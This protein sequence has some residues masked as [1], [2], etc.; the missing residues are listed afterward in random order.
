MGFWGTLGDIFDPT[1][2]N[3]QLGSP[4]DDARSFLQ[5]RVGT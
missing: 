1:N 2:G 3:A 5:K 4:E